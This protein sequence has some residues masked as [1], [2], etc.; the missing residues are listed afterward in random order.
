MRIGVNAL[1]LIPG[2]VGGTEVYLRSL[3]AA[4]AEIDHENTYVIF[5]NQETGRD[6]VPNQPNFEWAPAPV[7]A[8]FR[9][10]R[11]LW[12]QFGLPL[13]LLEHRIDV[14]FNPGFT[15]PVLASCEQVTVFH[16]LQH[17]RHPEYFRWF[18]L[19][20]W[21]LFL[22]LS[23]MRSRH[24]IAVSKATRSDLLAYYRL[25]PSKVRV[26][27]HGVDPQMFEVGRRRSSVNLEPYLLCVSTL[28]AHKNLNRLVSAFRRFLE[29]APDFRLI[30]AGCRGFYAA[31]LERQV[32]ALG[33]EHAVEI[34]GWV[35]RQ[36]LYELFERAWGFVYPSSFEG[37][38]MP[39]TEALAAGVP[40]ACSAIE[41]LVTLSG[42]AA[43]HFDPDDEDALFEALV[44]LSM[45][46]PLRRRLSAAGPARAARYSWT[47]AARK[48]LDTL[49]DRK[50]NSTAQ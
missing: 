46:E 26:V 16:D 22:Y 13:S 15:A 45:D 30:L 31:E 33:L 29:L 2:A 41:P 36:K 3:L 43:L 38:G 32:R 40:T 7:R 49:L 27:Q 34:T 5:T 44:R 10:F 50:E 18:D 42:Q 12:E 35:E 9:P 25:R 20:F 37:F 39:V 6:L 28:H 47:E 19:P 24:L 1:Y 4:L 17:M 23:A 14:L 21:R 48:T 8:V 11:I